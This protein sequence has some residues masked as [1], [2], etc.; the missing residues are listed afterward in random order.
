MEEQEEKKT[1]KGSK[2]INFIILIIMIGISVTMYAKYVGV[3]TLITKEYIVKS[4]MIPSSFSGVK[5]IYFSDLLYAGGTSQNLLDQVSKNINE[6]KPDIVLFG[7]GLISEGYTISEE[8]KNKIINSLNKID[9]N[10]G[11]YAVKGSNEDASDILS[12]GEFTI[13]NNSNDLIYNKDNTPIYLVGVG[14][15]NSGEYNLDS[16]FSNQ[17]NYYTIMFTHEGDIIDKVMEMGLKPNIIFAGNSLGGE[18]RIPYYGGIFNYDG[19]LNYYK[20]YENKND[21]DIYVS[22]G[23]GTKTSGM[24]LFNPPSI[25][26]FRLKSMH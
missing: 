6:L 20:D 5:I 21:I 22:S 10:L 19:S 8:E 24:R 25:S 15:Y 23:I 4:E 26:L 12:Q 14:S 7:G 1:K 3:N 9:A 11:K 18:V 13:L 16:A 2:I 17:N